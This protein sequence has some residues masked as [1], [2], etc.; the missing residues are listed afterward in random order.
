MTREASLEIVERL[1]Q[2]KKDEIDRNDLTC[3]ILAYMLERLEDEGRDNLD[4]RA[5]IR[6]MI[7][8]N[9]REGGTEK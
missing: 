8:T 1:L 5:S 2:G 6:M 9:I 7:E 3:S 4:L